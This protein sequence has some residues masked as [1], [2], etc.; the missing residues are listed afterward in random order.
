MTI[1]DIFGFRPIYKRE[2]DS[3]YKQLPESR[4]RLSVIANTEDVE[5]YVLTRDSLDYLPENVK[6]MVFHFTYSH[7]N[8][9]IYW[10]IM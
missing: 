7:Y 2:V 6:V 3:A 8:H 5:L 9:R 1:G 10:L 4:A